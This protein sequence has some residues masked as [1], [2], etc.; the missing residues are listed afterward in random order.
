MAVG[1]EVYNDDG[2]LRHDT[3]MGFSRIIGEIKITNPNYSFTVP[4]EQM[5]GDLF[6][7]SAGQMDLQ[8]H[9]GSGYRNMAT[10]SVNGNVI[11]WN[12][13]NAPGAKLIYGVCT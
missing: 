13:V 10:V 3:S 11:S 7:Y 6:A 12:N 9:S 2:S 5:T 1:L 4:Q 8:S